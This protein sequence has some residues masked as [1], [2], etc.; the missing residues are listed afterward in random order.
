MEPGSTASIKTARTLLPVLFA[1]NVFRAAMLSI[2]PPEAATYNRFV[3]P[4]LREAFALT[5][6]NNHVL[7]TLLA[8]ISTSVFHLTDLSLRLPSLLGGALY[9]WAVY[10]L[11]RRHFGSG[12]LFL[13]AVAL[14][15]LNPLVL[16]YLSMAR[17]YGLAL[18]FWMWALEFLNPPVTARNLNLAGMCLGLSVAANLSFLVPAVA[19]LTVAPH[20]RSLRVTHFLIPA[21]LTA[22]LI[23]AIPLNHTDFATF[24]HGATSLRQ[25]MNSLTALSLPVG[26]AS[27]PAVFASVRIGAA[28]LALA[29]L[30]L[31][32]RLGDASRLP[33][34]RLTFILG[35]TMGVSFAALEVGHRA[36]K[37]AFPLGRSALYFVPILT[38]AGLCL[39]R[40]IGWK[41]LQ[42]AALLAA[43]VYL[44]QFHVRTYSEWREYANGRALVKAI[45]QDAPLAPVRVAAS[46]GWDQVLNYYRARYA[47]G[48]WAPVQ[49]VPSAGS[50]DYYVL[51]REDAAAMGERHLHVV[52]R[53]GQVSVAR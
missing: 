15:S 34:D 48:R 53:D 47:L 52:F 41:P 21:F 28:M 31:A 32:L 45:R 19:L 39:V 29:T 33:L 16:D 17:G 42:W 46:P 40:R 27:W 49:A 14:L 12:P 6:A 3:G 9:L 11:A 18:A 36:F 1:V 37:I 43:G 51:K 44:F 4:P 30:V 38:L 2:T 13:A 50:F 22:F 23:L 10:R 5:T 7:N 24:N 8:R 26:Q 25:T 35:C 20:P